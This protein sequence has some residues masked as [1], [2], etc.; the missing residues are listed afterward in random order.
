MWISLK[1]AIFRSTRY[2]S[3]SSIKGVA[4]YFNTT[5]EPIVLVTGNQNK[6]AEFN[7]TIG[8]NFPRKVISQDIDLPE[9][10][11]EPSEVAREKCKAAAEKVKG[12]CLVEDT[13]LC[14]NALGGMPGPYI[15]WFLAKLGPA[16]LH[17]LLEGF[18]DK[19]ADAVCIFAYSSGNPDDE[20][21]LFEGRTSGKI[22]SP[23]GPTNFGW[24]PCF[25]PDGFEMTYAEMKKETKNKI[26]HRGKA[27]EACR[28]YFTT[29]I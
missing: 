11:G 23:R 28:K 6:L 16:G 2:Y 26:S 25:Q 13:S 29:K 17:K 22:V 21:Q 14:F 9:Y 1:S 3:R 27:V 4:S 15:K 18:D 20:I 10:Q 24:D 19:T 5:M 7:Q 12:P 8:N